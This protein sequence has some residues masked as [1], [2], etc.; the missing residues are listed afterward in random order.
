MG[1]YTLF[2]IEIDRDG[3]AIIEALGEAQG[4]GTF[5]KA[6]SGGWSSDTEWKWYEHEE[7]LQ[8]VSRQYPLSRITVTGYGESRG[9]VWRKYFVNGHM[10]KHKLDVT[11]AFPPCT[12]M[13]PEANRQ[14][15][16]VSVL[17]HDVPVEVEYIGDKNEDE[18]YE[19][20]KEQL[21]RMI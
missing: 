8:E 7:D 15:I 5:E 12:L 18:L 13:P 3:D 16:N 11:V 2:E 20:A 10:E 19:M 17:G 1:Y 9:D 21:R 4:A 6:A 14:T